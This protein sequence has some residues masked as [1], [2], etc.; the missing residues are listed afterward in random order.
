MPCTSGKQTL[1][2]SSSAKKQNLQVTDLSSH[3]R[4]FLLRSLSASS[5]ALDGTSAE[6]PE[7]VVRDF[8][9]QETGHLTPPHL[10]YFSHW[11]LLCCLEAATTEAKN[12]QKNIWLQSPEER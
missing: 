10:R 11:L 4:F 5:R 3:L 8:L 12:S 6:A 7:D 2:N 9:Q 1:S